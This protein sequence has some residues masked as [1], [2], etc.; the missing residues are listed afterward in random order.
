MRLIDLITRSGKCSGCIK[1]SLT[2][3]ELRP[4]KDIGIIDLN[5]LFQKN[6]ISIQEKFYVE[7][8]HSFESWE[9][10]LQLCWIKFFDWV[11]KFQD[12][13]I[14]TSRFNIAKSNKIHM[15]NRIW[16]WSNFPVCRKIL[17]SISV[18]PSLSAPPI[19]I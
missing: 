3:V 16:I 12:K 15:M 8:N 14:S 2:F 4:I 11:Y 7:S 17:H 10:V 1:I 13:T 5:C 9:S 19:L 6:H 18:Y